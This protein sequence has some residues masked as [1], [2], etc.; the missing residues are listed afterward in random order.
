VALNE[1]VLNQVLL[2][3]ERNGQDVTD[4]TIA[5]LQKGGICWAGPTKWDGK[6]AMRFSVSN[7]ST[8][9]ADIERCVQAIRS[10]LTSVP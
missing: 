3:F 2:R 1:V 7:W 6:S 10:A 5:R 4:A 8:T 9:P